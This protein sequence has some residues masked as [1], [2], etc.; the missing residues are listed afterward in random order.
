MTRF[1]LLLTKGQ[2]VNGTGNPWFYSDIG[3]KKGKILK[4]G[5]LQRSEAERTLDADGFT[6]CPGFIDAHS[7]SDMV[8]PFNPNLNSALHQGVTTLIT[9]QCG[10]SLAPVTASNRELLINSL[11]PF[12]PQNTSLDI[13]WLT[14]EEYLQWEIQQEPAANIGHLLG[15][16]TLRIAVLGIEDRD[17]SLAEL[18]KMKQLVA[19]AMHAGALGISTGLI[20]PPGIYA[21]T[22]ELVELAKIV[23]TFGGIYASHIRGEGRTLIK[24]VNEAITIGET[25]H[26]PIEISHHK[27]SGCSYWGQTSN[28][29][30]IIDDARTRGID[31]TYDQ[32]PYTAGMTSLVTLLPPWVHEGGLKALLN[33]LTSLPLRKQIRK[34]MENGLPG[35]ENIGVTNGWEKIRVSSVKT[36]SNRVLQGKT[37]KE[38]ADERESSDVFTVLFDLILEEEGEATMIIF[39]MCEDDVRQVLVHPAQMVGSDSWST[40]PNGVMGNWKPHPR[41]YGTY[42]RILGK[43]VREEKILTFEDAIRRMTAFPAQ[44][45]G[46]HD[47]GVIREGAWADL[48]VLDAENV[49]D[50]ADYD[51]PHRYPCGVQYVLVNGEIVIDEGRNTGIRVGQVISKQPSR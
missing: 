37:L 39:S 23:A 32:Y 38:I 50:R 5:K 28:T 43:Y 30:R 3:I 48:V 40:T 49:M 26:L 27:A 42:P 20:Y 31:V 47:R 24:A 6:I 25:A 9:G 16:G 15:H 34:D 13:S 8:I 4:I 7:H 2:I 35:W 21:K 29:L 17:P 14:F 33:R 11:S 18:N 45:Y 1:D 36:E 44:R 12:T 19:E 22:L 51:D 41:F 10:Y 46:L